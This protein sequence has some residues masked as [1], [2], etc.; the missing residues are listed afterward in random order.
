V[1]GVVCDTS[2]RNES[3]TNQGEITSRSPEISTNDLVFPPYFRNKMVGV[4][5]SAPNSNN[6]KW[7][8]RDARMRLS[9]GSLS[10]KKA[11]R[12]DTTTKSSRRMLSR[13]RSLGSVPVVHQDGVQVLTRK[14]CEILPCSCSNWTHRSHRVQ[15]FLLVCHHCQLWR[16]W[17]W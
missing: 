10:A 6:E 3:M 15:C 9:S 8:S 17:C 13:E 11:G 1:E 7:A 5:A 4:R 16:Q 12:L 2:K 14:T